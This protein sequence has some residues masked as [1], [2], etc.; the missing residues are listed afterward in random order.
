M[1]W[2]CVTKTLNNSPEALLDT[3]LYLSVPKKSNRNV[4][5][6]QRLDP[7]SH[8]APPCFFLHSLGTPCRLLQLLPPA[9]K[10]Q[11]FLRSRT[12]PVN[13]PASLLWERAG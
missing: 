12:F 6:T 13:Y 2:T 1:G 7:A 5:G 9:P 4:Q 8:K 3:H 10:Q 11:G